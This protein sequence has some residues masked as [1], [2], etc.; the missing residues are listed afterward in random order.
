MDAR[1]EHF[2]LLLVLPDPEV[3]LLLVRALESAGF[4]TVSLATNGSDAV[5][6]LKGGPFDALVTDIPLGDLDGWRLSRLVRSGV[7]QCDSEIP[8]VVVTRSYS[9]RI[10][11]VTAKE[12]EIDRF[13]PFEERQRL[14]EILASLLLQ[15]EHSSRRASL[16]VVEDNPDTV[17]VVRRVLEKRFDIEIAYD[18]RSG[19]AAWQA[20]RHSLVLLDVMLPGMSGPEVLKEILALRP[21]QS[22]VIMTA[23]GTPERAGDLVLHGAADFI[24]KPFRAEQLRRVCDI[25]VRR[26][27]FLQSNDQFARQLVALNRERERALV[28]LESIADGVITTDVDGRVEI[29]NPVAERFTGWSSQKARGRSISE[30]FRVGGEFGQH[31]DH[32][33]VQR[34]LRDGLPVELPLRSLL[35]HR[36]GSTTPIS[37]SVAPIKARGGA[38]TGTV[39]VFHDVTEAR[40]LN[41]QLSYQAS[42]DALTGLINR[43]AFERQLARLEE[44]S[45]EQG[46]EHVLGYLDLD[47]F[48]LV[49]DTCGHAAGDQLLREVVAIL[50]HHVRQRDTVARLGGDEFGILLEYCTLERGV[51]VA[52]A[53]RDALRAFRFPWEEQLFTVG[54]SI[55]LVPIGPG[56]H[57]QDPL[58]TADA[59]CYIAKEA[60]R[61]RIHVYHE[62]DDEL[63]QRHGEMQWVSRVNRALE[64]GRFQLFFQTICPVIASDDEGEH[65]ELLV[66]MVNE[67]G[68][69]V[70]PGVFL[71]AVER[72]GLAGTLD[73]WVVRTAIQWLA[74]HPDRLQRL[75]SC[76]INLSGRTLGDDHFYDFASELFQITGV[77]PEKICFEVTETVAITNLAKATGFIQ[78]FKGLGCRFALDDFGSGMSSF[79]YLKNLPVDYLKI[80][81]GFVK[82]I[83]RDPIDLAMVRSINEIGH[84]MGLKTIAE[85][86][87]DGQILSMLEA[88]GVDYAQGFHIARPQPLTQFE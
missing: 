34:V 63:V 42:H 39:M 81:G 60:G 43:S 64:E 46:S 4:G 67:S 78:L 17:Q 82:D 2:R 22:V 66:R 75:H 3:A 33:P 14:P 69:M 21:T 16:L 62:G 38:V 52:E 47:Q 18:G 41:R 24:A 11:E 68:E 26:E 8:I 58:R 70:P 28:T 10:A 50:Q 5:K 49:N 53:I 6:Q 61:D 32:D 20:R 37:A 19:L 45:Q 80:D 15:T 87:E 25:A 85:F 35:I 57:N 79:A 88:L 54:G 29:L 84:T 48:K 23:D 83:A 55:G 12:F 27:D 65:Y 40:N 30:V 36:T 76:A 51:E 1:L 9:E 71:P 72:Y 13:L 74:D 77:S 7:F 44:E 73:R 86:V 56:M 31:V 59:A